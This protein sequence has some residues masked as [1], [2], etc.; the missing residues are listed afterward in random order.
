MPVELP[1]RSADICQ[2]LMRGYQFSP[3]DL[4][5][6]D[7]RAQ[8]AILDQ[9]FEWFKQHLEGS[10][11]S[12][13]RDG[14][15]ILLEKEQKELSNE[16]RQTIVALFLLGDL[17]LEKGGSYQDL[18]TMPIRWAELDWQR[19]GYSRDYLIQAG[20]QDTDGIEE[21]W[22]RMSR[23]GLV[24]HDAETRTITLR[25]PAGRILAMARRLH[26]NLQSTAEV[27]DA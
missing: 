21:L 9:H 18:F 23:K 6:D 15:I 12:L 20:L 17:W 19:D 10:G 2:R 26:L 25:D 4:S 1:S 8:Y 7:L 11:F 14:E 3:S 16:E 13:I 5:S 22:R 27:G 24:W